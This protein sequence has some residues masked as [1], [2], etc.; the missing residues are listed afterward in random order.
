MIFFLNEQTALD[1]AQPRNGEHSKDKRV[2]ILS[3]EV[4]GETIAVENKKNI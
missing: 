2:T 4:A 1:E 3:Y